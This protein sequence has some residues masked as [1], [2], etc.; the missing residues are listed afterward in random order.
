MRLRKTALLFAAATMLPIGML[1]S[2]ASAAVTQPGQ[3]G[4]LVTKTVGT[5]INATLS[6]CTPVAATGAS[7]TGT[8][9][10]SGA[11]S[12]T[13]NITIKWAAAK[14]TTK[15]NLKFAT[16]ASKGKCPAGTTSRFKITGAVTGGTGVAF[17]TIK[18]GQ[19][20]AGSVC[21]GPKGYTLEPGTVQKF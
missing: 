19:P 15:A 16:Q 11:P 3:C 14:G 8:F 2:P 5:K 10:S 7:G 20:L 12:G 17:K 1:A 6:K 9:T 18:K 4:K 21:A 13:L